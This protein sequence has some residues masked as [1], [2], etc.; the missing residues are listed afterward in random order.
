MVALSRLVH[1]VTSVL[2][3][4]FLSQP[5]FSAASSQNPNNPNPATRTYS[6][7]LGLPFSDMKLPASLKYIGSMHHANKANTATFLIEGTIP[8]IESLL[9]H[10]LLASQWIKFTEIMPGGFGPRLTRFCHD[11]LGLLTLRPRRTTEG[12]YLILTAYDTDC[13]TTAEI[14]WK[15][16]YK[17]YELIGLTPTLTLAPNYKDIQYHGGGGSNTVRGYSVTFTV[18]GSRLSVHDYFRP[19]LESH[20]WVFESDWDLTTSYGSMWINEADSGKQY[21]LIL[22]VVQRSDN[23]FGV[24]YV[25]T[26]F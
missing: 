2:I 14:E 22:R 19:Q 16:L 4:A 11:Q 7:E 24:Q 13:P 1:G 6:R 21:E 20:G 17:P 10:E 9:T 26:N 12:N 18:D 5:C 3:L 15:R 23:K 8:D 25:I